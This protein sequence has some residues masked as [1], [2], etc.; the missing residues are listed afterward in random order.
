[1]PFIKRTLRMSDLLDEPKLEVAGFGAE[2]TVVTDTSTF[3]WDPDDGNT[4]VDMTRDRALDVN[5]NLVRREA[6]SVSN[7]PTI[8]G[9]TTD[10]A[11]NTNVDFSGETVLTISGANYGA[12]DSDL[13]VL[14]YVQPINSP[15]GPSATNESRRFVV[16]AAISA[17]SVGDDEITAS[18]TLPHQHGR[19]SAAKGQCEVEVR[20]TKRFLKSE[21]FTGLTV[22]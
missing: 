16:Q 12:E 10:Q 15:N 19:K 22:V 14:V 1:M 7:A 13:E 2:D 20:N 6:W 9:I 11:T 18:V 3:L 8:T 21:K 17:V 5:G 4:N